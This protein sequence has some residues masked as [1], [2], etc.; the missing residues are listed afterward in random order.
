MNQ[1]ISNICPLR[2]IADIGTTNGPAVCVEER[3]AWWDC[4][5]RSCC[6]VSGA[7]YLRDVADQLDGLNIALEHEK[8]AHAATNNMDGDGEK[9]TLAGP[10]FTSTI[11]ENGGNVK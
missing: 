7:D 1:P 9:Q 5:A 8:T 2:A 11:T 4:L 10:V 3:C 6:M